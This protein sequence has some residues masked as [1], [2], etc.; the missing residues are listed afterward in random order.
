MPR[1]RDEKRGKM[2]RPQSTLQKFS[3]TAQPKR[4]DDNGDKSVDDDDDDERVPLK[5]LPL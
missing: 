4:D 5:R 1:G 3:L 2:P